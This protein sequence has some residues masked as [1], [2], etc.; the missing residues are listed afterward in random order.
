ML[1]TQ[2]KLGNIPS[3]FIFLNFLV[4][5]PVNLSGPGT[6]C[7][8]MFFDFFDRDSL[9]QIFHFCLCAFWQV[10]P[11]KELVPFIQVIIFLAI[12]LF[13]SFLYQHFNVHRICGDVPF[14]FVV[15]VI[16][17]LPLFSSLACLQGVLVLLIFSKNQLLVLLFSSIDF[18]F[19]I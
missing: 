12:K 7:L 2:N 8:E 19:S 1:T 15:L 16:S 17:V 6:F 18:L 11:F 4:N 3:A 13:M 14:L 5:L 10:V 9:I